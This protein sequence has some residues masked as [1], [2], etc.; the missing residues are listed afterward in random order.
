MA[1]RGQLQVILIM[2]TMAGL[3]SSALSYRSYTSG[4]GVCDVN[5]LISCSSVYE[6]P[7]AR[8]TFIGVHLSVLAPI[9]FM[10]IAGVTSLY[11]FTGRRMLLGVLMGI[12]VPGVVLVPYLVYLELFKAHSIC[13]YCTIMHIVLVVGLI[14]IYKLLRT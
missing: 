5:S 11:G 9:Y 13:I 3:L 7:E 14:T 8:L 12:L 10:V 6:I 1:G 4:G 2:L